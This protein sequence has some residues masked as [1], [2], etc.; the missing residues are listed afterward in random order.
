MNKA[1]A[2]PSGYSSV[3]PGQIANVVTCLEMLARPDV[4]PAPPFPPELHLAALDRSDLAAYRALFRAVGEPWLWSSRLVMPDEALAEILNDPHVDILVLRQADRDAG[5]LELDFRETGTCELAFFGLAA[6]FT[7][8][9]LGRTL[10][11]VAIERAWSQPID[12]FWVHTCTFDHPAAVDF[13]KRSGFTP[14]AFQVEIEPDPRLTGHL[15][16]DAAPQIPLI[17]PKGLSD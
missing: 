11:N 12:R 7:G 2:L 13:Y 16:E 3:A 4:R 14:F 6:G 15:P 1:A 9:R 10:M 17:R 8:Q 5:I